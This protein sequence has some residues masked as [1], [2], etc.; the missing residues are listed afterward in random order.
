MNTQHT[1]RPPAAAHCAPKHRKP[2]AVPLPRGTLPATGFVRLKEIVPAIVPVSNATWWRWVADGKAPQPL[3]LS[4]R[5]TVWRVE[6][7]RAF[8]AQR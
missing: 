4:H 8:L 6:D 5:V 7:I 1:H 2:A 3:K